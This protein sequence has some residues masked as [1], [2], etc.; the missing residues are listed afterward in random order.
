MHCLIEAMFVAKGMEGV[1]LPCSAEGV[2]WNPQF[3][4]LS[5][6]PTKIKQF[7]F[8]AT[9]LAGPSPDLSQCL[10]FLS[11]LFFEGFLHQNFTQWRWDCF[12]FPSNHD[13]CVFG[14]VHKVNVSFLSQRVSIWDNCCQR[15]GPLDVKGEFVW[16]WSG[17]ARPQPDSLFK[18]LGAVHAC[19][20]G[21]VLLSFVVW[22]FSGWEVGFPKFAS[23]P[24]LPFGMELGAHKSA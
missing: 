22:N 4:M 13:S 6:Y 19:H 23:F 2:S 18:D 1:L 12:V 24:A 5:S 15:E 8:C 3:W 7:H 21:L 9:H 11:S 16:T 20:V 14:S 10:A 17:T